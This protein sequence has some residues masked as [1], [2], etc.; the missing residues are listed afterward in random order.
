MANVAYI[1]DKDGKVHVDAGN[2]RT[3]CGAI[4][5]DNKEDWKKTSGPVTCEKNGCKGK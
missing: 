4:T 2:G 5:S 3:G 1:R